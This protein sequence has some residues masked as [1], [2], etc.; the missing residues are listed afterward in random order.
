LEKSNNSNPFVIPYI[1]SNLPL[2]S[3]FGD[4]G[5]SAN[6]R[7]LTE[8][9]KR[10]LMQLLSKQT[11]YL[12]KSTQQN[13]FDTLFSKT[14]LIAHVGELPDTMLRYEIAKYVP[15]FVPF[16]NLITPIADV[17]PN[18]RYINA[19][20]KEIVQA[21][22]T[23]DITKVIMENLNIIKLAESKS[24][25]SN[26]EE[27]LSSDFADIGT[28]K[29]VGY[30]PVSYV[31]NIRALLVWGYK[32]GLS[33][34]IFNDG[35][36]HGGTIW[37]F[38]NNALVKLINKHADILSDAGIPLKA[39]NFINYIAHHTVSEQQFPDAY[40][41]VGLAFS[42]PRFIDQKS[43]EAKS[44]KLGNWLGR[45]FITDFIDEVFIARL[46]N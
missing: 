41:V 33:I 22:I 46:Q 11:M 1:I 19:N 10:I 13:K 40:R 16:K 17:D 42:D 6:N 4:N 9:Q 27:W 21:T 39:Y 3:I 31:K 5:D 38:D 23:N 8:E 36:V 12:Y 30:L 34:A 28:N 14:N 18:A 29:P 24:L 45:N 2:A 35:N 15:D 25:F 37:M 7:A 20:H 44:R 43:L 26:P 32:K